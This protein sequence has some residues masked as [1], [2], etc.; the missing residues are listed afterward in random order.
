MYDYLS[1]G[2][3]PADES[4][5]QVGD[6][7]YLEIATIEMNEYVKML[8]RMFPEADDMGVSFKIHWF[9]HDFGSYG[10]VVA[11]YMD[12]DAK[13]F[14]YIYHIDINSPVEWDEVALNNLAFHKEMFKQSLLQK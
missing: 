6:Q 2:P 1:L 14:D 5:A 3:T 13:A 9:Y 10:E 8:Y 12:N 4:C 11:L 7:H